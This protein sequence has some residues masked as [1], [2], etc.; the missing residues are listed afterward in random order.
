MPM[1]VGVVQGGRLRNRWGDVFATE[2]L[3]PILDYSVL[4]TAPRVWLALLALRGRTQVLWLGHP[5]VP[6]GSSHLE[7]GG[8]SRLRKNNQNSF[9]PWEPWPL[10]LQDREGR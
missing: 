3:S 10:S 9:G 6:G 4:L 8:T 7:P 2:P 1:D 5:R